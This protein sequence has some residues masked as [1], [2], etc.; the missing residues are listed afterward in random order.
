M[1]FCYSN[2]TAVGRL[3]ISDKHVIRIL[4][5]LEIYEFKNCPLNL[6]AFYL[7]Q[8]SATIL[9]HVCHCMIGGEVVKIEAKLENYISSHGKKDNNE[10]GELIKLHRFYSFFYVLKQKQQFRHYDVILWN[11]MC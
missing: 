10:G 8:I 9:F 6:N 2:E 4:S 7:D 1:F 5:N 11:I 3:F